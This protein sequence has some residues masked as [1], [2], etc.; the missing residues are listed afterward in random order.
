MKVLLFAAALLLLGQAAQAQGGRS[1][2]DYVRGLPLSSDPSTADDEVLVCRDGCPR[3]QGL[4]RMPLWAL[5]DFTATAAQLH[6][7][8]SAT[9]NLPDYIRTLPVMAR[10]APAD[11]LVVFPDGCSNATPLT[12]LIRIPGA[13]VVATAARRGSLQANVPFGR[14][15]NLPVPTAADLTFKD[16]FCSLPEVDQPAAANDQVLVCQQDCGSLPGLGRLPASRFSGLKPAEEVFYAPNGNDTTG[17]GSASQPFATPAAAKIKAEGLLAAGRPDIVI[18]GRQGVYRLT[19]RI[20]FTRND[21]APVGHRVEWISYPHEL[22]TWT[23]LVAVPKTWTA[24]G[25]NGEYSV[26]VPTPADFREFYINGTHR[27]RAR[28]LPQIFWN[29]FGYG[30]CKWNEGIPC[31]DYDSPG[32]YNIQSN[33][34]GFGTINTWKNPTDIEVVELNGWTA[35]R[36][37]VESI[38]GNTVNMGTSPCFN[39]ERIFLFD[40]GRLYAWDRYVE[41]AHELMPTCQAD[42]HKFMALQTGNGEGCWYFDRPAHTLYYKPKA[43]ENITTEDAEVPGLEDPMVE[44]DE[45]AKNITLEGMAITGSSWLEPQKPK[46][47]VV[48]QSG[49]WCSVVPP[50]DSIGNCTRHWRPGNEAVHIHF[51]EPENAAV[52]LQSGTTE[53]TLAHNRFTNNAPVSVRMA[54]NTHYLKAYANMFEENAGGCIIAGDLV[55]IRETN[56]EL[57]TSN[58]DLR[59]NKCMPLFEYH[60]DG[61][62]IRF[63][64]KNSKVDHNEVDEAQ[65]FAIATGWGFDAHTQGFPGYSW[66]NETNFNKVY[67][68]C[69]WMT[70][71][72]CGSIYTNGWENGYTIKENYMLGMGT[73]KAIAGL[74]NARWFSAPMYNDQGS[75]NIVWDRNV[76]DGPFPGNGPSTANCYGVCYATGSGSNTNNVYKDTFSTSETVFTGI[77]NSLNNVTVVGTQVFPH[78]SPPPA[79]QAIINNAGIERNV[80]PGP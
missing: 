42:D 46:G 14:S 62:I 43:G 33:G 5:S 58:I 28:A 19:T 1:F 55:D 2:F 39:I 31:A 13:R 24:T 41:N 16:Y 77:T 45:G 22:A 44:F 50:R 38:S 18:Y 74:P 15:Q 78:G 40:N 60:S 30:P 59:D 23:G 9:G 48:V 6:P 34:V 53:V 79:A 75:S 57:Q 29:I 49:F 70:F 52:E 21:D 65:S 32:G 64:A 69:M 35:A 67:R 4:E 25:S 11:Q 20:E 51:P 27:T 54:L 56:T 47:L 72:D 66:N 63:L 8:V 3:G 68:A 61:G 73:Y 37:H 71:Y 36:C 12:K 80:T 17:T 7:R 76:V 10:A 26:N